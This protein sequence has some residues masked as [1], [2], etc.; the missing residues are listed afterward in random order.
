MHVLLA[1]RLSRLVKIRVV[2][3]FQCR[4]TYALEFAVCSQSLSQAF[5]ELASKHYP[6]RL[7]TF[8]L[9][10]APAIFSVLWNSTQ[11]LVDATTRAKIKLIP[12]AFFFAIG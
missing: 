5:L 11:P 9:V 8:Y 7:H 1:S 10:A 12:Y 4:W 6:E 2:A 3:H